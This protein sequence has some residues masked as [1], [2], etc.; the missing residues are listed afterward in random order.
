MTFENCVAL[1][2]RKRYY[3]WDKDSKKLKIKGGLRPPD[4]CGVC[5]INKVGLS[6]YFCDECM[7]LMA[8]GEEGIVA[9]RRFKEQQE[10]EAIAINKKAANVAEFGESPLFSRASN[11]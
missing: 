4:A 5:A 7:S 8:I 9:R 6:A 1:R 2:M 3:N 11:L 10:L